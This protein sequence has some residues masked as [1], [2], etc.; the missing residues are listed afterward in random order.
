M[1][2]EKHAAYENV[3]R[4]INFNLGTISGGN[5]PSS[6]A[7]YCSC[8]IRVGVYPGAD[9]AAMRALFEQQIAERAAEL[10]VKVLNVFLFL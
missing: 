4:P 5:W 2:L 1:N 3:A 6:V 10:K 7:S 8:Q 9:L